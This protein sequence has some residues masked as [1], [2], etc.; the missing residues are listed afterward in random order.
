[1]SKK[2]RVRFAPSP[3]GPLHIGGVRT[4]LYNYLLAKKFDGQF[5]LR[6]EDTDQTRY[7][8]GAEDYIVESLKW[9]GMTPDEGPEQGG[10]FGPYRQSERKDTYHKYVNLLVQTE[11]AYFAFDTPEE[12]EEMRERYKALGVHSPKYDQ[13]TRSSMKNSLTLSED[14]SQSLI[15]KGDNVVVRLKVPEDQ[16]IS[17]TD[18][19]RGEVSFQ[20]AELDDKVLMKADGMPTYH[21]ANVVDDFLMKIS[22]VVRGEEW[23]SSTGHHVLLYRA[24]GWESDIPKFAHLPLI[25]KPNGK[26]KLSK[27]DGAKFGFPVFPLD[28]MDKKEDELFAGFRESGFLSSAVI[29]FLAFLGW[30]PGTEQE[31]FSLSELKDAFSV[32]KIIK[33]GAKFNYDKA[34]WYNQQYIIKTPDN[35]LAELIRIDIEEK[36]GSSVDLSFLTKVCG[37][38][39]ER[40]M[41]IHEIYSEGYYFFNEE[42]EY[43]QKTINKKYKSENALHFEN[44]I[45]SLESTKDWQASNIQKVIKS[46]ITDN[47]LSFGAILPILRICLAG[48][49]KGPDVFEMMALLGKKQVVKRMYKGIDI[50]EETIK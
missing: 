45:S 12:L 1:M 47:Q 6:I 28:W 22:H 37:L 20:S 2:V 41:S 31:I 44:I 16:V 40:V 8:S 29:N 14:E 35:E 42:F 38:M 15:Q 50:C 25:L 49:M 17:F 21:L 7:V 34:K 5:L 43:D 36:L 30:N 24:F 33:S 9:L 10:S 4:A 32:D 46:Y 27:R 3:T 39:K 18:E 48:T 26:G 19:V 13:N 23:L 11:H